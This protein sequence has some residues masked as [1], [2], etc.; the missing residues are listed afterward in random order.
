MRSPWENFRIRSRCAAGAAVC[1]VAGGLILAPGSLAQDLR[2]PTAA[3][4]PAQPAQSAKPGLFESIGRWFDDSAANFR[5]HLRG[6]KQRMDDLGGEAAANQKRFN[7]NAAEV[8]KNAAEVTRSAVD[9]VAKLPTARAMSGRERCAVAPN[10][11]PDCVA[12]AETLCRK[13]GFSTGKSIDFTSA[14]E[15]PPK[16]LLAAQPERAQC[17]TVTFISKAMCQ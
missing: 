12:A 15:C 5:A 1:L 2:P 8:G 3:A 13:H 11:A 17:T 10:G 6:A 4:P 9:A 7:E 16:A 14:E